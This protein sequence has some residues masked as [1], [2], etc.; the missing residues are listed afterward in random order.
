MKIG[1]K[2]NPYADPKFWIGIYSTP[3]EYQDILNYISSI[4]T[5]FRIIEGLV[6]NYI[7]VNDERTMC[8]VRLKY[9]QFMDRIYFG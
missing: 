2:E 8:M 1:C 4:E 3:N 5:P 6:I 7:G 9:S